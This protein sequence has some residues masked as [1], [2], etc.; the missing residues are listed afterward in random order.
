MQTT[1]KYIVINRK[2]MKRYLSEKLRS[3]LKKIA[4]IISLGR[5]KDNRKD[6]QGVVV[7][8]GIPEYAKILQ[9]LTK[10]KTEPPIP[11]IGSFWKSNRN[12]ILYKVTAITNT[13]FS[14]PVYPIA[15]VHVT[16]KGTRTVWSKNLSDWHRTM[17][18]VG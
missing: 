13:T 18:E 5:L 1:D 9:L 8:D 6:I 12:A 4:L 3:D 16:V 17:T 15:V 2:D 14:D 7:E 10:S 11:R